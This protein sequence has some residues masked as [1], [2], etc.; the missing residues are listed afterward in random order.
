MIYT[1]IFAFMMLLLSGFSATAAESYDIETPEQYFDIFQ[2]KLTR[3]H[4]AVE[5]DDHTI[6]DSPAKLAAYKFV[7]KSLVLCRI[8]F[9]T[10][11]VD[12][13]ILKLETITHELVHLAQ[14]CKDGLSNRSASSLF[15][16][17]DHLF[18]VDHMPRDKLIVLERY[19]SSSQWALEVEAFY[20][21][22]R[23]LRVLGLLDR[24]CF[25]RS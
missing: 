4:I 9:S 12:D 3:L 10:T 7:S 20:L 14:D 22:D 11:G 24:V 21:E 6:C 25:D 1:F 18:M 8:A 13:E 17:G 5:I 16:R 19:Y 2:H 15:G 23:P